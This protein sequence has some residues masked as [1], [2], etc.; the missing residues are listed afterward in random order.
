VFCIT[1][2]GTFFSPPLFNF[3]IMQIYENG[4]CGTS[5]TCCDRC[6]RSLDGKGYVMNL[7]MKICGICDYEIKNVPRNIQF[8]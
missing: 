3:S 1:L 4:Y 5:T 7:G 8:D 2:E 6:G